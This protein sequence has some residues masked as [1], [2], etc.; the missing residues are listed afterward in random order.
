MTIR[1]SLTVTVR[2]G[3]LSKL[4]CFCW[5][6][7]AAGLTLG[8]AFFTNPYFIAAVPVALLVRLEPSPVR[9]P[10]IKRSVICERE[11]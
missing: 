5:N 7:L 4:I 11:G 3:L 1:G 9:K 8:S 2:P 10:L 6:R